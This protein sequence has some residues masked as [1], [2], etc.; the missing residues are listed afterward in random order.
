MGRVEFNRRMLELNS[1]MSLYP[2]RFESRG[3][4]TVAE[5]TTGRWLGF[6][7]QLVLAALYTAYIDT[8]LLRTVLGGL[9]NVSYN[10]FGIHMMRSMLSTTGLYLAYEFFVSYG[11]EHKILYNF[12]QGSPG[13]LIILYLFKFQYQIWL[14]LTILNVVMRCRSG[15]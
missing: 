3:K 7:I 2:W 13:N 4:V 14:L 9:E 10:K 15:A 1:M 12:T 11:T 8:T 6:R 5:A